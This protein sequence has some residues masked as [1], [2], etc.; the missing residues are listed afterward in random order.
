[1][2][3]LVVLGIL[4]AARPAVTIWPS[5]TA[6]V[7]S[8]QV[9]RLD[10]YG[11]NVKS[12]DVSLG[13]YRATYTSHESSG[14]LQLEGTWV[15]EED[16]DLWEANYSFY[17]RSGFG[18]GVGLNKADSERLGWQVYAEKNFEGLVFARLG[19]RRVWVGRAVDGMVVS[20]GVDA[21]KCAKTFWEGEVKGKALS[22]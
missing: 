12:G 16:V 9:E 10:G 22:H 15:Y 6:S 14:L 18:V 1:M 4:L 21:I 19:F 20:F 5:T 17:K 11:L 2:W 13:Y 7:A 8:G 3:L